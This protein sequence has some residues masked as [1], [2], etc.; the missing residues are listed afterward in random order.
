MG[1]RKN[2]NFENSRCRALLPPRETAAN[3]VS[4]IINEILLKFTPDS[5]CF[6]KVSALLVLLGPSRAKEGS[7]GSRNG[8]SALPRYLQLFRFFMKLVALA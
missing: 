5:T 1:E 8:S 6:R 4:L 7:E 2:K 3:S